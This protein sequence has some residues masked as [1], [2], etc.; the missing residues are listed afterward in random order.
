MTTHFSLTE[1]SILDK[2]SELEKSIRI[3]SEAERMN[4]KFIESV[5]K[6]FTDIF[7]KLIELKQGLYNLS[8]RVKE[9]E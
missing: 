2:F 3:L 5:N 1:E 7:E 4:D 9:L 6:S 8:V